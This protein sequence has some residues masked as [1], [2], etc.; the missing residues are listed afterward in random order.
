MTRNASMSE[1]VIEDQSLKTCQME[2]TIL[3]N[4]D[5]MFM[6]YKWLISY[7]IHGNCDLRL[8]W[9]GEAMQQSS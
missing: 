3:K 9:K 1:Y 4:I 7:I 8:L 5:D 6:P 2:G